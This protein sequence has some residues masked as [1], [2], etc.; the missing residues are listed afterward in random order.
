MCRN[1]PETLSWVAPP[2]A[3]FCHWEAKGEL[4]RAHMWIARF[5][6]VFKVQL[7][8]L[9]QSFGH[10]WQSES[11]RCAWTCSVASFITRQ[12]QFWLPAVPDL[13]CCWE[14]NSIFGYLENSQIPY[15]RGAGIVAS[16][17]G[18]Y[19]RAEKLKQVSKKCFASNWRNTASTTG[20][21]GGMFFQIAE[22]V[23]T[24]LE[25]SLCLPLSKL[26]QVSTLFIG[27]NEKGD[28]PTSHFHLSPG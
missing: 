26:G 23:V 22:T 13:G 14:T 27:W 24:V 25:K 11:N 9:Q 5:G 7:V 12:L 8:D 15:N 19:K 4:P 6:L 1:W 18:S 3:V 17:S 2:L 28:L 20:E 10:W 21:A 16:C